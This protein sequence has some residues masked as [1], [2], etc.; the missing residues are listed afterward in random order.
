MSHLEQAKCAPQSG[1]NEAAAEKVT[2]APPA[3]PP[4]VCDAA[5]ASTDSRRKARRGRKIKTA[6]AEAEAPLVAAEEKDP[7]GKTTL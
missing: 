7:A 5:S 3:D 6:K 2:E 4:V 1:Q